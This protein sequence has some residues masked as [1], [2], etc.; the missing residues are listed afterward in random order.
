MKKINSLK[1]RQ[2]LSSILATLAKSGEPIL[3]EKNRKPAAVIISLKDFQERFVELELS[4]QRK[5]CIDAIRSLARPAAVKESSEDLL[6]E[7][8]ENN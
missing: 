3:L 1:L 5:E 8:R 6:H 7:I 4:R 2:S